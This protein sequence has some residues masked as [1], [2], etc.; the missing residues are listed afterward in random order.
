MRE[1]PFVPEPALSYLTS[2]PLSPHH[3]AKQRVKE[4]IWD[5]H[6]SENGRWVGARGKT[7]REGVKEGWEEERKREGGGEG[8]R[9][10]G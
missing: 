4:S 5:I 3:E 9:G 10:G 2:S 1:T 6:F 7:G 8:G